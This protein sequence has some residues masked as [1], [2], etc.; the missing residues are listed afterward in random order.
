MRQRTHHAA[1][2][3]TTSAW[4]TTARGAA[5]ST[6][7]LGA[8]LFAAAVGTAGAATSASSPSPWEG[9]A[10]TRG[11]ARVQDLVPR[12]AALLPRASALVPRVEDLVSQR[13]DATSIVLG[14]DVLFGFG[15]ADLPPDADARLAG[16]LAAIKDGGA[17]SVRIEG[18]TDGVGAPEDNQVLSERRAAAVE[19]ALRA[20][21]GT[22][23]P[24]MTSA[25]FGETRPLRPEVVQGADDP[26][27]RAGNRRV[28]VTLQ[29]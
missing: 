14:A 17:A 3:G 20:A 15:A 26:G 4:G 11:P 7:A 25:G 21:L 16:V 18:H 5:I 9:D 8:V 12:G 23:A 10:G 1:V 19:A 6:A 2:G 22:A 27:A 28:E 29:R 13:Q 24:P